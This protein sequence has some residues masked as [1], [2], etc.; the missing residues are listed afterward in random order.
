MVR[1][2]TTVAKRVTLGT[3]A[4][5]IAS[6]DATRGPRQSGQASFP[7]AEARV[8]GRSEQQMTRAAETEPEDEPRGDD[9]GAAEEKKGPS[10]PAPE[11][12]PT[13]EDVKRDLPGVP[14]E[15]ED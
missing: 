11:E 2:S 15:A 12:V 9:D 4:D 7:A 1:A 5:A 3:R 8:V 13:E 6:A 14:E 10:N